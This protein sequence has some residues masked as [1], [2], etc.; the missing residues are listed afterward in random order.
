MTTR[1]LLLGLGFWGRNWYS[2]INHSP[3]AD[4]VGVAAAPSDLSSLGLGSGSGPRTYTDYREAIDTTDAEAALIVLPTA[5]HIDAATRELARGLHVL[6]EKPLAGSLDEARRLRDESRRYP[7]QVYMVNQNYRWRTHTQTMRRAI[8]RGEIGDPFGLHLEFRQPEFLVGDRAGLDMPMIQDMSIHHFDLIRYLLGA[9]GAR[10]TARS[11]RPPWSQYQGQPASEVIVELDNGLVVGYSGTWAA[12]GR[13]TL[14]DGDITITGPRGCLRLDA[15]N[16]VRLF[17]DEGPDGGEWTGTAP[18]DAEGQVLE[19]LPLGL[20]DLDYS[21]SLFLTSVRNG[22][23]PATSVD[24]NFHSF[25]MVAAAL[26]SA[27]TGRPVVV[28]K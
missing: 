6:S 5:L 25:A 18:S 11:F 23:A 26:E 10:V 12:R 22:T 9:N 28:D 19:P 7:S 14:W 17:R 15:S 21:L 27:R 4:V 16:S 13:Y 8:E 20:D 2:V 24:D 3:D 1:I